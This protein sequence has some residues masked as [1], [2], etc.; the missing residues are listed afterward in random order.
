[1]R[2]CWTLVLSALKLQ[3][4]REKLLKQQNHPSFIL[5]F[6]FHS[7]NERVFLQLFFLS[8][9]LLSEKSE[10]KTFFFRFSN[11]DGN[12][13][14]Q[15]VKIEAEI[16]PT[17]FSRLEALERWWKKFDLF[18]VF[19]S[20]IYSAGKDDFSFKKKNCFSLLKRKSFSNNF[21][22]SFFNINR[23]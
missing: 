6:P 13:H 19:D 9:F 11:V 3:S 21:P 1:M 10:W 4:L 16:G 14:L 5:L 15:N 20:S 7:K 12:F 2:H 18:T 23:I 17:G 22:P 8:M